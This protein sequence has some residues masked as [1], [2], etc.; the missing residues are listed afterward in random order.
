[1]RMAPAGDARMALEVNEAI[2]IFIQAL[3]L[4]DGRAA[5]VV[6]QADRTQLV[7]AL[8]EGF[9]TGAK[10]PSAIIMERLAGKRGSATASG[11]WADLPRRVPAAMAGLARLLGLDAAM[12][13]EL[14]RAEL[15]VQFR[16]IM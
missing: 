3:G 1:M 2:L 9:V 4:G 6:A 15:E 8:S 16:V 12:T 11:V 7:D 13:A 5:R 14:H 10:N